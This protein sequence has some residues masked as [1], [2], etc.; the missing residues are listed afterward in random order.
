MS[1]RWRLTAGVFDTPRRLRLL[2]R[3]VMRWSVFAGL[4]FAVAGLM[5]LG[6][7]PAAWLLG[8]LLVGAAHG[9][10]GS[11]LRVPRLP[12]VAAQASLGAFMASQLT[13][14]LGAELIHHWPAV[15]AGSLGVVLAAAGL[16][17][18]LARL[19]VLPGS[20]AVWGMAPGAATAMVVLSEAFGAD[21]RL[22]ALMQ[23]LRIAL[24]VST[25]AVVAR[26]A[27]VQPLAAGAVALEGNAVAAG[28]ALAAAGAVAGLRT[29]V[30]AGALLVPLVL[31][32]LL[33]FAG[34]HAQ[35]PAVVVAVSAAV[36]GAGIGLSF[37]RDSLLHAFSLLPRMLAAI[38]AL[39]ALCTL[40]AFGLSRALG[41]DFF[42]L[43]L[44]TSP[45]GIDSVALIAAASHADVS[46][47][48]AVQ[49]TR[50]ALVM[51]LGPAVARRLAR[52]AVAAR[53]PPPAP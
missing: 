28:L 13:P 24:V 23:Y 16:G 34:L 49:S 31:G 32:V 41:L 27:G 40:L 38:V 4:S 11:P 3:S 19:Q 5:H 37:T 20:T 9:A 33:A 51:V 35:V 47:V 46:L 43:W 39:M 17:W 14:A 30:P 21:A 12:T 48:F 6:G 42:T 1:E 2:A 26:V 52:H 29:R 45:G 36:L 7:L 50:L 44:A 10:R 22:V 18:G 53:G 25:A 15:A 8:P